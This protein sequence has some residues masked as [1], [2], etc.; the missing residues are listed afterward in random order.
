MVIATVVV[1]VV[2]VLMVVV[3]VV[4]QRLIGVLRGAMSTELKKKTNKKSWWCT[5]GLRW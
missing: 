3:I 1:A 5:R 4:L 2:V